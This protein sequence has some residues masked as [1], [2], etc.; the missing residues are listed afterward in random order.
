MLAG[1]SLLRSEH[2]RCLG[3]DVVRWG[4]LGVYPT[5]F[6]ALGLKLLGFFVL[7]LGYS[8]GLKG[9]GVGCGLTVSC[10]KEASPNISGPEENS[11]ARFGT[12]FQCR[13][14]GLRSPNPNPTPLNP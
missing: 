9:W 4:G 7:G 3:F 2:S 1:G 13:D 8:S 12:S 10:I 14:E 6:R 11:L 5:P